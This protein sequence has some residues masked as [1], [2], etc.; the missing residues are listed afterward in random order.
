VQGLEEYNRVGL[1]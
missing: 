1:N